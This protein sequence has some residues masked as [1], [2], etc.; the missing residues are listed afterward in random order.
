[1]LLQRIELTG[2]MV[3]AY[4]SQISPRTTSSHYLVDYWFGGLVTGGIAPQPRRGG[5]GSRETVAAGA[6]DIGFGV[7]RPTAVEI[8]TAKVESPRHDIDPRLDGGAVARK[9]AAA[10]AWWALFARFAV[11]Y[12]CG[13]ARGLRPQGLLRG[14]KA[15]RRSRCARHSVHEAK[16]IVSI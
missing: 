4:N 10:Q 8:G 2:T 12:V 15:I 13:A 14:P 3:N 16:A 11:L 5:H 1:M 7:V 6:M 9:H